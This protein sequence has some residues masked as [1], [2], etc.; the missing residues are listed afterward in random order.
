MLNKYYQSKKQKTSKR[1]KTIKRKK[2]SKK[3]KNTKRNKH[4]KRN[5]KLINKLKGGDI[6]EK[7]KKAARDR[8]NTYI[9]TLEFEKQIITRNTTLN[10]TR[11]GFRSV[12]NKIFAKKT[13]NTYKLN[14]F[15]IKIILLY[16][17]AYRLLDDI[18]LKQIYDSFNLIFNRDEYNKQIDIDLIKRLY[19]Q[20]IICAIFDC[21]DLTDAEFFDTQLL[22]RIKTKNPR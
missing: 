5:I 14:Y 13:Y 11:S 18:K 4:T 2:N 12:V 1:D 17:I 19:K 16:I 8:L 15:N 20:Y 22:D 10:P 7:D 21:S 9:Q 3:N 6:T